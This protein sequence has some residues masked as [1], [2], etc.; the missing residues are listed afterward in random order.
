MTSKDY[1]QLSEYLS[2]KDICSFA[3]RLCDHVGF[4]PIKAYPQ[5]VNSKVINSAAR[6]QLYVESAI[7][8]IR[9]ALFLGATK[10]E[11]VR[12]SSHLLVLMKSLENK[13]DYTKCSLEMDIPSL[14]KKYN[15]EELYA[16]DIPFEDFKNAIE[17]RD[18]DFY[19]VKIKD[20]NS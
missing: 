1:R 7:I 16:L 13:L 9:S 11:M 20:E 10:D 3:Q 2:N 19:G 14:N 18:Q 15:N 6:K 12:F 5:T 17:V 8:H 4:D